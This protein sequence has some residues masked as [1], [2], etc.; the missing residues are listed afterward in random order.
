MK[1][2][3]NILWFED[4]KESFDTKK[5]F[6]K[7]IVEDFGFNFPEPRNEVNGDNI[8]DIRYE[9]YDL[10]IV[11][12]NLGRDRGTILIDRIRKMDVYTEVV[13]YSSDGEDAVRN[14]LREYQIDGAYCAGRANE[15]FEEKV[16][17]VIETTVKKVQDVNNMRG[18]IMAETSDL[19][20]K[21]IEIIASFT[22]RQK[23]HSD[24]L[25]K[26]VFEKVAKFHAEL[27]KKFDDIAKENNINSLAK[28]SLSFDSYKKAQ[29][30]QKIIALLNKGE[31]K[32][33]ASFTEQ[34]NQ[35]VIQ[36]R[37]IF[38]H[39]TETM[40]GGK[41]VLVSEITGRREVFTHERCKEIRK[42]LIKH[43]KS[44]DQIN[45]HL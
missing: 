17:K 18:L 31:L 43:S 3:Y 23:G 28:S 6:V 27:N 19:D 13:F 26:Y 12:L 36:V 20:R 45:S 15:D 2:D 37:N 1:I 14:A 4:V 35:D 10:M 38:A 7:E 11:D 42:L 41:K 34:Y 24:T 21:M 33:L 25:N 30:I 22:H 16:R 40:E 5:K 32:P 29:A 39:V 44:L 9:N 8:D